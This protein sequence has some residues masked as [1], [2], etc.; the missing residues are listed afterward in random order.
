MIPATIGGAPN[1]TLIAVE[2]AGQANAVP[3]WRAPE[4]SMSML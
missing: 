2:Q 4:L 3:V 1:E